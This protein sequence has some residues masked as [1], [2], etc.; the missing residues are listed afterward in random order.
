MASNTRVLHVQRGFRMS[1][2]YAEQ[3]MRDHCTI[4]W[5]TKGETIRD[6]TDEERLAM[7]A[8]QAQQAK[9]EAPLAN[10][11]IP[12]LKFKLLTKYRQPREAYDDMELPICGLRCRWPRAA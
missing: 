4:T 8:A 3:V 2:T 7:R 6:T 5:V 12:G 1:K 10:V 11:E 9:R